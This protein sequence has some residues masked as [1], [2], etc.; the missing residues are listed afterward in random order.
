M[1]AQLDRVDLIHGQKAE[2]WLNDGAMGMGTAKNKLNSL[3]GLETSIKLTP[4]QSVV[5][6]LCTA[7]QFQRVDGYGHRL[8]LLQT[9]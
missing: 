5:Q 2:W 3:E 8:K 7:K 9:L 6:L 1:P 4:A